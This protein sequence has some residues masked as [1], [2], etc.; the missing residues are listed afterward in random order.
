MVL[1]LAAVVLSGFLLALVAPA[2][3]RAVPRACG[4][5][6]ALVP[7]S[8][9]VYLGLHAPAV[10]D[11]RTFT[12]G[13]A[14][15]PGLELRLSFYLDGLGLLFGLMISG[16]GALIFVYAGA[17][18]RGH[19]HLGRIFA[20]LLM[21]MGS[22]LGVVLSDNILTLF[23]FWELTSVASYLLIG[24]DHHR[25]AARAAALQ[26]L[27]TT[28]L[29]GLALMA[30][31]L[32]MGL[33]G[34]SFELST[35]LNEGDAL[36]EHG[37]YVPIALLVMLGCFTKSAQF[38]FHFWLPAAM[39]APTPVSAYLHSSTMVKAGIYLLARLS[40]AL[41]D[42]QLWT[43][44]LTL[45][46][47]ATMF[48]GAFLA[49]RETYL[50]RL[51]AYSTVSALGTI[52]MA[53]GVGTSDAIKA[54]MVFIVAHALYKGALFLIAGAIDHS[55]G[56]KNVEKLGGLFRAMPILGVA[57]IISAVSMA[58]WPLPPLLGFLS[59]E[60]VLEGLLGV[61][62]YGIVLAALLGLS[63]AFLV[64]VG[65]LVGIR[66]FLGR[67]LPTPHEPHEPAPGLLLGPVVLAALG[68]AAAV[69]PAL[70]YPLV[71][72]AASAVLGQE[73]TFY[74]TM[75]HG[76]TVALFISLGA[77]VLGLALIPLRFG[78]R[79]SLGA[80]GMLFDLGPAAW[81]NW[82]LAGVLRGAEVQTRFF[83]NGYLRFYLSVTLASAV[84]LVMYTMLAKAG[85][86]PLRQTADVRL[87]EIGLAAIIL[88]AATAAARAKARLTAIAALGL[89]GYGV[90][91]VYVLFGAPDL[92]MTQIAIETLAVILF[93]LVFYHL[94]D[95]RSISTPGSKVR[96]LAIATGGG[97][98]MT[99]LVL[100]V[101]AVETER[102]VSTYYSETAYPL[103]HG[104]NIVN[105][106]LVDFRV[107]DTLG[108]LVVLAVAG[109]GVWTLLRLTPR[110]EVGP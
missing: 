44:A 106:I 75:W 16:I 32:M 103:A 5:V 104:R 24:F 63:G 79:R 26:A 105:V 109:V 107:L 71:Q 17:Y 66:P 97:V 83:Q 20:Y 95:F 10:L 38:P 6:L 81:Y 4:W 34:G 11:G 57:A 82:L 22:M 9:A 69:S 12:A 96:D 74:L 53:L 36:R 41:G 51:L 84:G 60:L 85:L 3:A 67:R 56:E 78:V 13:W 42:T 100:T 27:L 59:K 77:A 99:A 80:F 76:W 48:I 18:L 25:A 90:A 68:L 91:L 62:G 23:V 61:E 30:G 102:G 64:L 39:E 87:Y 92:A 58:G 28:G 70:V 7:L 19:Q 50:K 35:L 86:P 54:A 21:F 65:Y 8:I 40:P 49:L 110:R 72:P 45:T 94:P 52:V 43:L 15:A 93:V 55:T 37:W 29:G 1:G 2:I 73:A 47:A 89:V 98:M 31:L 46:G 101:T 14:W 33:A 108:E 88:L